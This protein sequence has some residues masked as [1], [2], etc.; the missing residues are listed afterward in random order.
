MRL[1]LLLVASLALLGCP[2]PG[3]AA[4]ARS[5]ASVAWTEIPEP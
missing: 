2:P 3:G 5:P 4:S 1:A